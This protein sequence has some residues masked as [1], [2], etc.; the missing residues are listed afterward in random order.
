MCNT[1]DSECDQSNALKFQKPGDYVGQRRSYA[2][3]K[4]RNLGKPMMT[5]CPDGYI[6]GS[7]A[8]YFADG[9]NNDAKILLRMMRE[10]PI[11]NS[12][13]SILQKGD[14]LIL[15]RG[16][17][18]AIASV[19]SNGFKAFMP[20]LLDKTIKQKAFTTEQANK[21]R[22]TTLLRGTVERAN[23]RVKLMFRFFDHVVPARYMNILGKLFQVS[24]SIINAFSP[25]LFTEREFHVNVAEKVAQRLNMSN[26][27]QEMIET[28]G[29]ARTRV[30]WQLVDEDSALD[31]PEMTLDDIM[32]ITL[33]PYH[34]EMGARYN[35]QHIG[36]GNGYKYYVHVQLPGLIQI[37]L[38]SR[39][40]NGVK[41]KLWIEYT[42]HMN[43]PDSIC[44]YYC[45]CPSGA[46]TLG[47]CSHVASVSCKTSSLYRNF[48]KDYVLIVLNNLFRLYVTWHMIDS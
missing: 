48:G 32:L 42:P 22:Q 44:G 1:N 19:V 23:G 47:C 40:Q 20:S 31:F 27:L 39:H 15:D 46:R 36:R 10:P 34:V 8:M 9:N 30:Q 16:F 25:P 5:I 37:K 7:D 45:T 14:A 21:S 3:Y 17:Q 26:D 28:T 35:H 24:I 11:G 33:G 18:E 12:I 29:L 38:Q 43:G 6:I 4:K 13:M 2:G 41:H